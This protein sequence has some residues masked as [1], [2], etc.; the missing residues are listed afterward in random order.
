[1]S[2]FCVH[3]LLESLQGQRSGCD[4]LLS[5]VA[6]SQ[7]G[8]R[9]SAERVGERKAAASHAADLALPTS[10]FAA[11]R[12]VTDD[13]TADTAEGS[14]EDTTAGTAAAMSPL[15]A[16]INASS[17]T[18]S[19]TAAAT[20]S[21]RHSS[22]PLAPPSPL[23]SPRRVLSHAIVAANEAL[24]AHPE[25]G[26]LA[27]KS[28]S[29]AHVLYFDG[30]S[31]LWVAACG[32]S[33]ACLGRRLSG[34]RIV[35]VDLS[36]DHT[37]DLPAERCRIE[38][39]GGFVTPAGPGGFPPARVSNRRGGGGLAMSR[40][41]G[42]SDLKSIGVTAEPVVSRFD[43]S[44][45]RSAV[46]RLSQGGNVG[47]NVGGKA[48]AEAAQAASSDSCGGEESMATQLKQAAAA[49]AAAS[50]PASSA[51]ASPPNPPNPPNSA[52]GAHGEDDDSG[53]SFVILASD[54][55]WEFVT[56]QE[57]CELVGTHTNATEAAS[58]LV[59]AAAA[60]W[61]AE[62]GDYCDDITCIVV[63]LPIAPRGSVETADSRQGQARA[64]APRLGLD[65]AAALVD[66]CA[67]AQGTHQVGSASEAHHRH[68]TDLHPQQRPPLTPFPDRP[69]RPERRLPEVEP[70]APPPF[71]LSRRLTRD[72]ELSSD[73]SSSEAFAIMRRM[74]RDSES[75]SSEESHSDPGDL[76]EGGQGAGRGVGGLSCRSSRSSAER[77]LDFLRRLTR[78]S[79]ADELE[80]VDPRRSRD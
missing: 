72:S 25:L 15:G 78:D 5:T 27:R 71:G 54:G 4:R 10:S 1:M 40:A 6:A 50:T 76:L 61:R 33:R 2:R 3:A 75:M 39:A 44:P 53:D 74:T 28:G 59:E 8:V 69:D 67:P 37:P 62:A 36:V 21:S 16:G 23:S 31:T 17:A 60:R 64:T 14:A 63:F 32:D 77:A 49:A 73:S 58:D 68:R 43:L 51:S 41:L 55:V 42:D 20:A 79:H 30:P 66:A 11:Q 29:T 34:G 52:G 48:A 80:D 24:L 7:A 38:A 26:K 22:C 45:P 9:D 12:S 70:S 46:A 65:S 19:P 57:A 47:G 18:L 13:S 35:A 56:S